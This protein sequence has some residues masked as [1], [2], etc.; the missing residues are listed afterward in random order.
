M[1]EWENEKDEILVQRSQDGNSAATEILLRRYMNMVRAR[2]RSFFLVGGETDDLVQEGM[3]GLYGAIGDF[4]R[5]SGKSFK[6]FAYLCVTRHILDAIKHSIRRKNGPL[7]NS[8]SLFDPGL[9]D[10]PE[11]ETPEDSLLLDESRAEFRIKLMKELSDFE[12]RV[13]TMYLEGMSYHSI[14]EETGKDEKSVDNALVRSK[15]KLQ[16][17]FLGPQDAKKK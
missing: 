14:C 4:K 11:E 5:D 17:A 3:I 15:K 16:R 6:N 8:V 7:N 12:F 1:Q 13:V 9:S 2:A 10:F